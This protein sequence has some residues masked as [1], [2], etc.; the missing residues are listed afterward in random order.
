MKKR[1]P[2]RTRLFH[3]MCREPEPS[4]IADDYYEGDWWQEHLAGDA[5]FFERLPAD[6]SFEG[7]SVLDYGCGGGHTCVLLA[8]RG[9]RRVLGVDTEGVEFAQQ[10]VADRYPDLAGRVQ[11]RT[12]STADDIGEDTF[13]VVLS[14]NAFE[15]VDDPARYVAD[16]TS[17]LAPDGKLVIG[18]G[19]LWKSPYGGHLTHMT[20]VPWAH[21]FIPEA[22]VLRERR[23]YRPDEDPSRYEEVKGGL[24]RM[25]LAKFR[26]VMEKSGLE[27]QYL[28]LNRN[29]RAIAKA[30]DILTH[31]PGLKEYFTFS[32]HSIWTKPPATQSAERI[33]TLELAS[34]G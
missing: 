2:I 25:T 12:I 33:P 32:V 10:Q 21:L 30:L 3:A 15:H 28:E 22:V 24:N 16:M 4:E 14:K 20:K 26:A 18:F 11:F 5:R 31:I 34:S 1:Y 29:D 13:D 27:P 9:A 19:G 7:R 23:R 6:L 17:R 8:Q